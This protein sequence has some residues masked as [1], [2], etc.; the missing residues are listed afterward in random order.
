[1]SI[2]DARCVQEQLNL[3]AEL[4]T[5]PL[6]VP[7][8]PGGDWRWAVTTLRYSADVLKPPA[9]PQP[10]KPRAAFTAQEHPQEQFRPGRECILE[11]EHGCWAGK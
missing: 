5:P 6:R 7:V 8:V 9:P 2:S 10:C 4:R 11:L 1:M 3:T